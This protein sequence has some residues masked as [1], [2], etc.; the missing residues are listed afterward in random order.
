MHDFTG[1]F[2]N[3][4][5]SNSNTFSLS[6]GLC[7]YVSVSMLPTTSRSNDRVVGNGWFLVECVFR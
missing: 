2:N 5:N 6:S 4:S 3:V 1:C 7:G